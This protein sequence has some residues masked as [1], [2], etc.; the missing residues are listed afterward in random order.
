MVTECQPGAGSVLGPRGMS[1]DPRPA[2]LG[3]VPCAADRGLGASG[4]QVSRLS[5][6]VLGP[7]SRLVLQDEGHPPAGAAEWGVPWV[8]G[9][10]SG[11]R[12]GHQE[13]S[14][15]GPP[16]A[17]DPGPQDLA[18]SC[19]LWAR[20]RC[21]ARQAARGPR[22]AA[23]DSGPASLPRVGWGHALR[24]PGSSSPRSSGL[25]SADSAPGLS[26]TLAIK[27]ETWRVG[28][29]KASPLNGGA[30][31]ER[32]SHSFTT[33]MVTTS[34]HRELKGGCEIWV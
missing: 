8:G 12:C 18:C 25:L 14:L 22:L 31:W 30:K 6:L 23:W 32:A 4:P 10:G 29:G 33:G 34:R 9:L 13:A 19:A 15:A 7:P 28:E 21:R 20:S 2:G 24:S 3:A 26:G 1:C 27:W 16:Q 5:T 17:W 11:G